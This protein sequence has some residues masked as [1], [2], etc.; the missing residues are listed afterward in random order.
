MPILRI[1]NDSNMVISFS[2][3]W[4]QLKEFGTTHPAVAR[5]YQI[6]K[7]WMHGSSEEGNISRYFS[8]CR[9]TRRICFPSLPRPSF[10]SRSE[11]QMIPQWLS[12]ASTCLMTLSISRISNDG[13][14]IGVLIDVDRTDHCFWGTSPSKWVHRERKFIWSWVHL[15]VHLQWVIVHL[16]RKKP[17]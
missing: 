13:Q 5:A 15:R 12:D 11:V 7:V 16:R 4:F 6:T 9:T 3:I 14:V 8:L 1:F 10:T 17:R 2:L